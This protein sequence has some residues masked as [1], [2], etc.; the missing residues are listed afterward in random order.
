MC[1]RVC[2]CACLCSSVV[3]CLLCVCDLSCSGHS[4]VLQVVSVLPALPTS[5]VM[6]SLNPKHALLS[7]VIAVC[8]GVG[9]DHFV[10]LQVVPVIPAL[11]TTAVMK[12]LYPK[13]ALLSTVIAVCGGVGVYC[14]RSVCQKP[15]LCLPFRCIAGDAC[16][17]N[18]AYICGHEIARGSR[19]ARGWGAIADQRGASAN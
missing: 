2:V 11:P 4:V 15:E 12:S 18:A 16:D 13:H 3:L 14:C 17:A 1:P 8:G 5:A 19:C 10:S 7:T 9:V 6:K